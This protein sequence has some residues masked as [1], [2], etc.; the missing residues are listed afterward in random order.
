MAHP[1][2]YDEAAQIG[3]DYT[4]ENEVRAYDRLMRRIRDL[5]GEAEEIAEAIALSPDVTVWEIGTGTGECALRIARNCRHVFATDVSATM[6]ACAR[7]KANERNISNV[8]FEVG[9]FL[10]GS[11]PETQVDAVVSQ[12]AF[13]HLPDFWKFRALG[14][15]GRKLRTGGRLYLKDVVFPSPLE[16]YDA[17]VSAAIDDVRSSA[18]DELAEQ[19]IQHVRDEF[20]TFDWI[21]EGMLERNGLKL[22]RKN[23]SGFLTAYTCECRP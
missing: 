16:D 21:L 10:S 7:R 15:I 5:D 18:G 8:K 13:H 4:D 22:L 23:R 6:L 17:F 20:S 1:W 3:T 9:G 19:T 2:L 11:Q 14:T 12:L